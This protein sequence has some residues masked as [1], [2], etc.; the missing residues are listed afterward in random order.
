MFTLAGTD[1]PASYRGE[2]SQRL[3][4]PGVQKRA[5]S[6]PVSLF[7]DGSCWEKQ[8]QQFLIKSKPLGGLETLVTGGTWGVEKGGELS[9][10][11][12]PSG[13]M[14]EG[15]GEQAKGRVWA[16]VSLCVPLQV[17]RSDGPDLPG[18]AL[19]QRF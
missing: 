4:G 16:R 14:E 13:S 12:Q 17:G 9:P 1:T 19:G 3:A 10:S 7:N 18:R 2:R 6:P 11:P 15:A 5:R 8:R